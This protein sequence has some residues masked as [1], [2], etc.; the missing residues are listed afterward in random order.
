MDNKKKGDEVSVLVTGAAGVGQTDSAWGQPKN[1]IAWEG[2]AHRNPRDRLHRSQRLHRDHLAPDSPGERPHA[3]PRGAYRAA[4]G[5][6]LQRPRDQEHHRSLRGHAERDPDPTRQPR[7]RHGCE[8]HHP[9]GHRAPGSPSLDRRQEAL[10][11]QTA[12]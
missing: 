2:H 5:G 3:A 7:P 1:R 6:R 9:G 8:E 4:G 11:R 12:W 10:R